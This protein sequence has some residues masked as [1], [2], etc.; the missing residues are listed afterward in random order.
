MNKDDF[1]KTIEN[2]RLNFLSTRNKIGADKSVNFRIEID[3]IRKSIG[4]FNEGKPISGVELAKISKEW[5]SKDIFVDENGKPFVLF[6]PDITSY[7]GVE[8][9]KKYHTSWC[10]TLETMEKNQRMDRYIKKDD[11]ENNNFKCMS[12]GDIA[13]T[14]QLNACKNCKRHILSTYNNSNYFEVIGMDLILFF[15]TYGSQNILGEYSSKTYSIMYPESWREISR[16][17]REKNNWRCQDKNCLSPDYIERK[18]QLDVHHVNGV[19][20]D[21]SNGNLLVLC[22]KCHSNKPMHGHYKKLINS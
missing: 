18:N 12:A 22:K 21:V 6:I 19:K 3:L 2:I 14:K 10:T 5:K 9:E 16:R 11:L 4:D 8:S 7:R 20:S 17:L 1:L 15:E 13:K